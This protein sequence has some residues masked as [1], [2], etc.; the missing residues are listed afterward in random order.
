MFSDAAPM[1]KA[2]AQMIAP[3]LTTR[4]MRFFQADIKLHGP[5]PQ[6]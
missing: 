5:K 6:I 4:S 1:F 2:G 3:L